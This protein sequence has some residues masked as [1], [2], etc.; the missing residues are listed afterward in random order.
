M[1]DKPETDICEW[2][3]QAYPKSAKENYLSVM[4]F[5]KT[6]TICRD[7]FDHLVPLYGCTPSVTTTIGKGHT[8]S[9]DDWQPLIDAM[10]YLKHLPA[11]GDVAVKLADM[12]TAAKGG[13]YYF[14]EIGYEG[15]DGQCF[16]TNQEFIPEKK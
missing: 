1:S 9:S 5:N 3:G 10:H 16:I 7:C 2:C 11:C 12:F 4:V 13:R 8:M 14:I 15:Q 6:H